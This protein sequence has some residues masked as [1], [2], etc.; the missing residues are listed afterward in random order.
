MG[1]VPWGDHRQARAP[2]LEGLQGIGFQVCQRGGV[3]LHP[4]PAQGRGGSQGGNLGGGLRTRAKAP[5]L[6][7]P[8]DQGNRPKAL[9]EIE[10]TGPLHGANLVAADGEQIHPQPLRGEGN[11]QKALDRVGVEQGCRLL[12]PEQLGRLATGWRAPVSLFTS[13]MD[14]STVSGRRAASRSSTRTRPEASG[15]R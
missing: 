12:P 2:P 14:T 10:G 3:L 5:L 1:R 9:A 6:S 4:L 13:I 11:L 15:W 8:P 7:A